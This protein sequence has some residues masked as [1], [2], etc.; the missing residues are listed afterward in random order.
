MGA[1]YRIVELHI[2]IGATCF[3]ARLDE[4]QR[5]VVSDNSAVVTVA[6]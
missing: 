3:A 1:T 4:I 6:P 2:I 5:S